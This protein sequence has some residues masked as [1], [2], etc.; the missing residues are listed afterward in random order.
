MSFNCVQ[1]PDI[2]CWKW[3]L[4]FLYKVL[5]FPGG[6][7]KFT[8]QLSFVPEREEERV[9]CFRVLDDNGQPSMFSNFTQVIYAEHVPSSSETIGI[10]ELDGT[11]I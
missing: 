1:V 2:I 9:P 5:N 11:F 10:Y 7:V 3:N 6:K 4:H 8:P